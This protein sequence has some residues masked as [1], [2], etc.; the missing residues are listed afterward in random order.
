MMV[1]RGLS[2]DGWLPKRISVGVLTRV[3]LRN[4]W[5]PRWRREP[6]ISAMLRG[7]GKLGPGPLR[8]LFLQVAGLA[9][10]DTV[11]AFP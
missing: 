4:W 9:M 3:S 10:T 5:T 11:A 6:N 1:L 7:R 8:N 2:P